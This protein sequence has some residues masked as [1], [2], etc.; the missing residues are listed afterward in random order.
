MPRKYYSVS[1]LKMNSCCK[2]PFRQRVWMVTKTHVER[3]SM[4][5]TQKIFSSRKRTKNILFTSLYFQ[6]SLK[7]KS[8]YSCLQF[9]SIWWEKKIWFIKFDLWQCWE[10][11][12]CSKT[13]AYIC[14]N[15]KSIKNL[16]DILLEGKNKLRT[17]L[18]WTN[19]C[20]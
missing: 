18:Y 8:S 15:L 17:V 13:W 16:R 20:L 10:G 14:G 12:L 9:L 1:E 6:R 3:W 7:R 4:S 11:W 5:F 2:V 19:S